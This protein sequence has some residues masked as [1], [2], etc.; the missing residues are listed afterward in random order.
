MSMIPPHTLA[1]LVRD[2]LLEDLGPGDLTTSALVPEGARATGTIRTR[3]PIVAAGVD[4]ARAAFLHLDPGA[5]FPICASSGAPV[6]AGGTVLQVEARAA[7]ILSA[8]RTALNFL[9]RLSGIATRVRHCVSLIEGT[10]ALLYDTRK[11]TPGLRLLERGAVAAGG[12]CNHRFG[13]YDAVLIKDN[14]LAL[15]GGAGAAV[16]R[17]RQRHGVRYAIEVEVEDLD[18]LADALEAGADIVLLDNM[19]IALVRRAVEI[20]RSAP[21]SRRTL[22]EASGGIDETNLRAYAETGVDRISLG[23][24]T[25]SSQAA[26]LSLEVSRPDAQP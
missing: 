2:A 1:R 8:E 10:V 19:P 17:A 14:H 21:E 18:Q 4:A 12:G 26:D 3:T 9:A 20:A 13:L 25:H 7:A 15:A 24:L 6:G 16:R 22:L 5:A 23:S 11:T